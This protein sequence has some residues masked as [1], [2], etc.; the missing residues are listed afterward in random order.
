MLPP[1]YRRGSFALLLALA[2]MG[3]AGCS[4]GSSIEGTVTLDGTPVDGGAITFTPTEGGSGS[5]V[6]APIVGGKYRA[7]PRPA[8]AP[9]SYR[10]SI[11]WKK[12]TGRKVPTPGDQTV[13]MDQTAEAIPPQYNTNSTLTKEIKRGSNTIN[14]ELTSH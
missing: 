13:L 4:G 11:S 14:F 9:G 6:G 12:P 2:L 1:S 10:V 3:L 7:A 8:P 5:Q